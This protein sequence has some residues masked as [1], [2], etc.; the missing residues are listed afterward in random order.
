MIRRRDN[1]L[2]EVFKLQAALDNANTRLT[3]ALTQNDLLQ[4]DLNE[5]HNEIKNRDKTCKDLR[6]EATLRAKDHNFT[7]AQSI[8]DIEALETK[9]EVAKKVEERHNRTIANQKRDIEFLE[10]V[11][12]QL[13][14]DIRELKT[15]LKAV[16]HQLESLKT[17]NDVSQASTAAET[18]V[19]EVDMNTTEDSLRGDSE[20][21]ND[22]TLGLG[23]VPTTDYRESIASTLDSTF[24]RRRSS[25]RDRRTLALSISSCLSRQSLQT[26][27][28]VATP[29]LV[30]EANDWLEHVSRTSG[31]DDEPSSPRPLHLAAKSLGEELEAINDELSCQEVTDDIQLVSDGVPAEDNEICETQSDSVSKAADICD[32]VSIPPRAEYISV[33]IQTEYDFVSLAADWRKSAMLRDSNVVKSSTGFCARVSTDSSEASTEDDDLEGHRD[34]ATIEEEI[35]PLE[36]PTTNPRTTHLFQQSIIELSK[37]ERV[38]ACSTVCTSKTPKLVEQV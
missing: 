23:S 9:L 14:G 20:Q 18:L 27:N 5:A 36:R 15:D 25:A 26:V 13:E 37:A 17:V 33:G 24:S 21:S 35:P 28:S 11:Q 4:Y 34:H 29:S 10:E 12:Y 19:R 31:H 38:F 32:A 3:A 7:I 22:S 30:N 6:A 1:L 8:E 16:N 2:E